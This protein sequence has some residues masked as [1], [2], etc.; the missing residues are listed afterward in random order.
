[1]RE[2][3]VWVEER[4]ASS[5]ILLLQVPSSLSRPSFLPFLFP[6]FVHFLPYA[7]ANRQHHQRCTFASYSACAYPLILPLPL[8]LFLH[9]F[10]PLL[11]HLLFSLP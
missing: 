7:S 3:E 2:E 9:L 5:P 11:F 1:M 6:L 8:P 10:L 4:L